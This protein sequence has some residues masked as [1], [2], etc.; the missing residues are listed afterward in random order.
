V[1]PY[2]SPH[3]TSIVIDVKIPA[4]QQI[5]Y[6]PG[7]LQTLKFAWLQYLSLAIPA[8]LIFYSLT[9]FIFR[10]QIVDSAVTSDLSV[11]KRF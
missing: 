5:T 11:R 10:H 3:K 8:I 4:H 1:Q 2:A 6:I 9:G 7:V